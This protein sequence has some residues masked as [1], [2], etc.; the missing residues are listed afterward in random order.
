MTVTSAQRF[1]TI[2]IFLFTVLLCLAPC[3]DCARDKSVR[4]SMRL[5]KRA[6]AKQSAI[7]LPVSGQ[8]SKAVRTPVLQAATA[9]PVQQPS[10][11]SSV[12]TSSAVW[13]PFIVNS[14]CSD[15]M[16]PS[17]APCIKNTVNKAAEDAGSNT[18]ITHAEELI[19]P[20]FNVRIPVFGKEADKAYWL[21]KVTSEFSRACIHG[22]YAAYKVPTK[23]N[24]LPAFTTCCGIVDEA[25]D[26]HDDKVI[27]KVTAATQMFQS[28]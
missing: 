23:E 17:W 21:Q 20:D 22:E 14:S 13:A 3:S 7:K 27:T 24:Y 5:Q 26:A 19:F 16:S 10:L 11:S 28:V 2:C 9:N 15:G 12:K 25:A 8:N 18:R 4:L 6:E 1:R